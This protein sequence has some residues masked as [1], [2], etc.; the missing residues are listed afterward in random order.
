MTPPAR[1]TLSALGLFAI[2]ALLL[3]ASV[4][5]G[6]AIWESQS[7]LVALSDEAKALEVRA[8]KIASLGPRASERASP[9]FQAPTIT[10]AGAMLQQRVEN[11]VAQVGG[12]LA[13]SEVEIGGRGQESRIG[14]RAELTIGQT[15]MQRLLFN[16]ETGRP[17]LFIESFEARAPDKSDGP[18]EM[19]VALT[20]SGQIGERK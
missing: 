6:F 20:L 19:R 4:S 17:Y 8:H 11:E 1:Q 12:R 14:L 5:T 15:A 9:F 13:S 18:A 3:W 7:R 16:L 2:I 10:V